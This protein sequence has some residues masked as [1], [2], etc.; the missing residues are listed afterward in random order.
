MTLA[1]Y[2]IIKYVCKGWIEDVEA[3]ISCYYGHFE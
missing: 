2:I 1:N 3:E